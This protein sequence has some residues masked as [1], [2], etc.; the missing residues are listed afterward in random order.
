MVEVYHII[1]MVN[2]NFTT[3]DQVFQFLLKNLIYV[4]M[5]TLG[6]AELHCTALHCTALHCTALHCTAYT[7]FSLASKISRTH[8]SVVI[9]W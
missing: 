2:L 6:S 5:Y 9:L 4:H 8:A 1:I 3:T 7:Y